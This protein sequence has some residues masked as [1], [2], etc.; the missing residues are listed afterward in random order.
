MHLIGSDRS[1]SGLRQDVSYALRMFRQNPGFTTVAIVSLALGIGANTAIFTLIDAVL[2]KWLPV[3][4]PQELVV[5]GRNPSRPGIGINYPDYEFIRDHNH[6]Y[7]GVIACSGSGPTAF[8]AGRG[9][10]A[11]TQIVGVSMVSG[12][13]FD[14]LGV[15]PALGRVLNIEDNR[16]EGAAPYAVLSY[17]FWRRVFGGDRHVVGKDIRLNGSPFT[18]VGVTREGFNGTELGASPD[19][20]VPIMMIRQVNRNTWPKWNSRHMWWLVPIA[21]LK[22]GM[23][24]QQ[25]TAEL[26]ILY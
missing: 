15:R 19:I 13:Y 10:D 5:L 3:S 11:R 24:M 12:N 26:D 20:F 16:K 2:L 25:A 6:S 4:S 17:G 1:F 14:V 21:R 18:V 7:S 22:P 9:P 8:S 23:S